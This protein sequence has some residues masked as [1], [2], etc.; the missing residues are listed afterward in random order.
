METKIRTLRAD[1]IECRVQSVTPTGCILLI[2]KDARVDMKILDEVYGNGN[3]QRT[4]EVIGGNLFCNIDIWDSE[5]KAWVRKQDVGTES[6]TEKEKGQ[7]SDSFKRAGFNIGIGR[8]LYTAP[9][10]WVNLRPEEITEYGGKKQLAKGINFSVKEIE[11]NSEREITKLVIVDQKGVIRFPS[12]K[13]EVPKE[14][15]KEVKQAPT[16]QTFDIEGTK[17]LL[18]TYKTREEVNANWIANKSLQANQDYVNIVTE[19]LKVI[20]NGT[21]SK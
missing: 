17:E 20:A 2:Y 18:K 14:Q 9:F 21:Q 4:H 11:Y 15:P 7:A 12:G 16:Q 19:Q 3:W 10:T 13:A 1:E 8:E 6:N 5:K